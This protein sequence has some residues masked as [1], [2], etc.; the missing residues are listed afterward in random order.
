MTNVRHIEIVLVT[1]AATLGCHMN[2][3]PEQPVRSAFTQERPIEYGTDKLLG[4]SSAL[5]LTRPHFT[6][7]EIA[8]RA[9]AIAEVIADAP[10]PPVESI[11]PERL[12][13]FEAA[14]AAVEGRVWLTIDTGDESLEFNYYPERPSILVGVIDRDRPHFTEPGVYPGIGRNAA[15]TRAQACADLLADS[16][17][18]APQSYVRDP[19]LER[20]P[21]SS[22]P[23]NP[24]TAAKIQVTDYYHFIFG[25]APNGILLGNS[26]LTIDVDAH[27]GRCFRVEVVFIDYQREGPVDLIVSIEDDV[28]PTGGRKVVDEGR[29]VYWLDHQARTA[30]VEPRYVSSYTILSD[31]GLASRGVNFA[32]TLSHRPPVVTE[33]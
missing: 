1:M 2:E 11:T 20:A 21:S 29:I 30:I 32:V 17:V 15:L 8:E 26:E 7:I 31:D 4:S 9:H 19:V 22:S 28:P 12:E 6:G 5:T 24:E 23:A 3:P 18:I 25:Q 14:A 13:A 16:D 10:L 33:F 27:S